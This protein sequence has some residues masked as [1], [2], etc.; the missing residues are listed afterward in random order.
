MNLNQ[1]KVLGKTE[2]KKTEKKRGGEKEI[3]KEWQN[4][5]KTK[6]NKVG[7]Q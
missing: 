6:R 3:A 1:I 5:R 2:N 7:H 4:K